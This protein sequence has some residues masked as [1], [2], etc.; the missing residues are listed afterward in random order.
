MGDEQIGQAHFVLQLVKHID[1]L[2][3]DGD[4][5]CRNR[6]VADNELRVQC[7]SPSD[8]DALAL[9]AGKLVGIAGSMFTVEPHAIHEFQDPMFALL[10]IAVHLMDVQRF[11]DNVRDGHAGVQRRI[12]VLEDHRGLLAKFID[13][14]LGTNRLALEANLAR[15]RL[16]E[17]QER[18][19]DRGLA[20]AGFTHQTESLTTAN[21]EGHIVHRLQGLGREHAGVDWKVLL[22]MADFDQSILS[23]LAHALSPPSFTFI[24]Q[25]ARWSE[26]ISILS[27]RSLRQIFIGVQMDIPSAYS[28]G[29]WG[30]R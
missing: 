17:M 26:L 15:S 8:A 11:A 4:I 27:Q 12:R 29:L 21:A 6:L 30:F 1:D 28:A 9:T 22:Q 24:Q 13:I 7:E 14:C 25:A 23:V 18:T 2:S 20:A 16:V 19:P 10:P 5:Q 3:L